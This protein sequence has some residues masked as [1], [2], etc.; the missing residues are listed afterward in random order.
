MGI[1]DYSHQPIASPLAGAV[2]DV[3][4]LESYLREQLGDGAQITSL[5]DGAATRDAVVAAFRSHLGRARSG[6]TALFGFSGHGSQETP[7]PGFEHEDASGK[8]Q[9]LMLFDSGTLSAGSLVWPLADKELRLLLHEVAAA[10]PHVLAILDCCHSGDGTRTA[11]STTRAREWQPRPDRAATEVDRVT[12]V[13]LAGPRPVEEFLAGSLARPAVGAP[14]LVA[15][16]ACGSTE[17]ASESAD[18]TGKWRGAFSAAL[19]HVLGSAHGR[20][21]YRS[22]LA[23]VAARLDTQGFRQRPGLLAEASGAA[24]AAFLGGVTGGVAD[25]LRMTHAAA[26]WQVNAGAIAGLVPATSGGEAELDCVDAAGAAAGSVRVVSV[27]PGTAT[28][29][30]VGW[31]PTELVYFARHREAQST[32]S[33]DGSLPAVLAPHAPR[34]AEWER[35]LR[36]GEGGGLPSPLAG[37]VQLEF[38]PAEAGER[39]RPAERVPLVSTDGYRLSYGSDGRAPQVFMQLRNAWYQDLYVALLVMTTR[40]D[41]TV[42]FGSSEPLAAGVEVNAN[43]KGGPLNLTLPEGR[44][45]SR[46]WLQ[47]IVSETPFSAEVLARGPIDAVAG[48]EDLVEARLAAAAPRAGTLDTPGWCAMRVAVIIERS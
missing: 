18:E 34:V 10:G 44:A 11:E 40:L 41:C 3:R 39:S 21:D 19:L 35:L 20:A 37:A 22:L 30:P 28:V 25:G 16:Y 9:N 12:L 23:A 47:L 46:D 33:V 24:E 36:L 5:I 45:S 14:G 48:I 43:P 13:Q 32:A 6:D 38:V 15:L 1:D 4:Q 17:K 26:G 42:L 29:E 8:L 27:T 2:N 7:P 31:E